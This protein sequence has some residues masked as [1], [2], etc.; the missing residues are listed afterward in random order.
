[1][2]VPRFISPHN[3][4]DDD[5][6]SLE[7]FRQ[8]LDEDDSATAFTEYELDFNS[9]EFDI[10]GDTEVEGYETEIVWR[11]ASPN[12]IKMHK[13][14][15]SDSDAGKTIFYLPWK[16]KSVTTV[17]LDGTSPR[18]FVTSHFSNCRFTMKFHDGQGKKVTVMHV[19]GD[20]PGGASVRGST[21]RDELENGID[22]ADVTRTRRLSVSYQKFGKTGKAHMAKGVE[23]GTT[24]YDTFARVFG[25]RD[26]NGCWKFHA[27]NINGDHVILGFSEI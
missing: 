5:M 17:T 27:Q 16:R 9:E 18:Y 8:L 12:K 3:T 20:V 19:A 7:E 23:A 24:Y 2:S 6:P 10:Y 13:K 25:I 11:F 4:K 1:M 15:A 22:V 21:Q 14:T 26:S